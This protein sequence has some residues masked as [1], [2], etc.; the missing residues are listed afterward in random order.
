ME[1][2]QSEQKSFKSIQIE[3]IFDRFD[4]IFQISRRSRLHEAFFTIQRFLPR[5]LISS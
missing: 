5:V 3:Q 1:V 2:I 4:Y